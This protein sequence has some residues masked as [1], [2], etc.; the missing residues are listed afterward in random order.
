LFLGQSRIVD[1]R[2]E[3]VRAGDVEPL[4]HVEHAAA[5]SEE[6]PLNIWRI[7]VLTVHEND[8]FKRPFEEMVAAGY[9]PGFVEEYMRRDMGVRIERR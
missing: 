7:V 5:G 3:I 1:E 8:G 9:L 4:F 2:G 6:H